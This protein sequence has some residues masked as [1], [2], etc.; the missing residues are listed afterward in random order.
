MQG[1]RG[2]GGRVGEKEGIIKITKIARATPVT[3]VRN[4]KKII[5]YF[6]K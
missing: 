3:L 6:S 2:D 4:I 5:I 1:V